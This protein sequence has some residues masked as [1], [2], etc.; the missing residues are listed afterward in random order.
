MKTTTLVNTILRSRERGWYLF[1]FANSVA[2]VL[3]G[4]YFSKWFVEDLGNSPLTFNLLLFSASLVVVLSARVVGQNIDRNGPQK[5]FWLS[6]FMAAGALMCLVAIAFLLDNFTTA[7]VLSFGAFWIFIF[8]YQIGRLCHNVFLRTDI[9]D[10]RREMVSGYGAASNW[11]GSIF[12]IAISIPIVS[13][14]PGQLG[15]EYTFVLAAVLFIL[16]TLI[17]LKMMRLKDSSSLSNSSMAGP[18]STERVYWL[19][20]SILAIFLLFDAMSTVEKNL[21][22]FLSAVFSM[23]DDIQGIAFLLILSFA[24]VGGIFSAK[25][26][27]GSNANNWMLRSAVLLFFAI[28][29]LTLMGPLYIW[30]SFPIAGFSYGVLESSIRISYMKGMIESEAGKQFAV[31]TAVERASGIIGPL[32]W[33]AP[34]VFLEPQI[35]T[36]RIS[37]GM[38]GLTVLF[39]IGCIRLQNGK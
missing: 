35:E 9:I 15:R 25:I 11:A 12:G 36:Y 18:V 7:T 14:F 28:L 27:N 33:S 30:F 34:F 19:L 8:A 6:A 29:I 24:A 1:D 21:P 3:G 20:P 38:M 2:A 26:V 5:W 37:M 10:S 22:T 39:A 16:L 4:V 32:V 31:L 17:S 13:A 23:S